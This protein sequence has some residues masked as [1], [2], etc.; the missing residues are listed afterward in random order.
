MDRETAY[1]VAYRAFREE[2]PDGVVDDPGVL[3]NAI[4]DAITPP[5]VDNPVD[6]VCEECGGEVYVDAWAVWS[7]RIGQY[8][9]HSTF[10]QEFCPN[11]GSDT[12]SEEVPYVEGE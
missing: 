4:V 5:P 3:I 11:C 9:I 2:C 7:P 6:Y 8:E 1:G 12:H 10:E